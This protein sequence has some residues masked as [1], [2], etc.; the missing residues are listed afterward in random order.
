[1]Q[2]QNA[3]NTIAFKNSKRF[4]SSKDRFFEIEK[5]NENVS[6]KK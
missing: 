4:V 5:K 1:M 2:K 6:L 3:W